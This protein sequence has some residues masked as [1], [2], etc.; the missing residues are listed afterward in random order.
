MEKTFRQN[1]AHHIRLARHNI[2][3]VM[4]IDAKFEFITAEDKTTL[5][6]AALRLDNAL[7]KIDSEG[8]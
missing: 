2:A 7:R 1:L 6:F 5:V 8:A 3:R 4:M